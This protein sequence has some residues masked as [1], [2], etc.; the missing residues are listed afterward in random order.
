MISLMEA[1]EY[2]R[3]DGDAEDEIIITLLDSARS[4]VSTISRINVDELDEDEPEIRIGIL[5]SLAY[6]YEHREDADYHDLT[7]M[8][9]YVLAGVRKA[10]F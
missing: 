3:I 4:I 2:L 7:L 9:R 6:L 5:Y 1:K 8:L 10:A